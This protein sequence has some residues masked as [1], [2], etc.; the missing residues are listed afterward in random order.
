MS[1]KEKKTKIAIW[2]FLG[3]VVVLWLTSLAIGTDYGKLIFELFLFFSGDPYAVVVK[4]L[5]AI[6]IFRTVL[7][8]VVLDL[9][10]SFTLLTAI[11]IFLGK[12]KAN[13][14]FP[15]EPGYHMATLFGLVLIEELASRWFFLGILTKVFTS[16][17]SF[18]FLLVLGNL[19][20]TATHLPN[21]KL[22]RKTNLG[23]LRVSCIFVS[24]F[25]FAFIFI[26]FGLWIAVMTHITSNTVLFTLMRKK[27]FEIKEL[28][29]AIYYIILL[30]IIY[31]TMTALGLKTSDISPWFY[32]KEIRSLGIG[33]INYGVLII[34]ISTI[35]DM[36]A[37]ILFFEQSVKIKEENVRMSVPMLHLSLAVLLLLFYPL[38]FL[39][40]FLIGSEILRY[41][42]I[43]MILL[44][45]QR[46]DNFTATARLW[47]TNFIP[48][49]LIVCLFFSE[50]LG[51]LMAFG[52]VSLGVLLELI[53][54]KILTGWDKLKN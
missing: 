22:K 49:F 34:F 33:V 41:F 5:A 17:F 51:F 6:E 16:A 8:V 32:G 48:W 35:V 38:N 15:T 7:G 29:V 28:W 18:Y 1:E 40:S 43:V 37:A 36:V 10:A 52:V 45:I 23:F 54:H 46:T 4:D 13:L 14:E 19:I 12:S 26:K 27:K 42:V 2:S 30:G 44:S 3:S 24:G 21:T 9:L 47:L 25:F 11:I 20:W 50:P 39:L 31:L 53:P